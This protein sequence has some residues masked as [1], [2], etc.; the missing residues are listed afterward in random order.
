MPGWIARWRSGAS[1]PS[2]T[3]PSASRTR[4]GRPS[5]AGAGPARGV[6]ELTRCR[7]MSLLSLGIGTGSGASCRARCS[8]GPDDF[9]P[10]V[11]AAG[12]HAAGL[13]G[14]VTGERLGLRA[15]VVAGGEFVDHAGAG[16]SDVEPAPE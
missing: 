16:G 15:L 6:E 14:V 3:R 7:V 13:L 11:V 1:G 8:G 2:T 12:A 10:V 5:P 9:V 4:Q